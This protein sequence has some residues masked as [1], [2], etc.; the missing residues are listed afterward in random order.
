M[1]G[2]AGPA[3]ALGFIAG[4]FA[5]GLPFQV[6]A[7]QAACGFDQACGT[8][9]GT[10]G[11]IQTAIGAVR[12][13]VGDAAAVGADHRTSSRHGFQQNEAQGFSAGWEQERITTGIGARQLFTGQI[14]D[15]RGGCAGE[16][17]LQLLAVR[18]IAHQRQTGVRKGFQHG[19]DPFN[20]FFG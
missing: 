9:I 11:L 6:I 1:F 8:A 7:Q 16:M 17:F 12:D 15:K 2:G 14:T 5:K 20:L 18:A 10:V 13:D 19:P 4:R 3:P